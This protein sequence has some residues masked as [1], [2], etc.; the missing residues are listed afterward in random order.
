M[1]W[2]KSP[3]MQRH[4]LSREEY[5]EEGQAACARRFHDI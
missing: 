3:S 4:K 2:S 1:T 5:L